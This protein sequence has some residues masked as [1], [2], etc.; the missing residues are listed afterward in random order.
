LTVLRGENVVGGILGDTL[1]GNSDKNILIGGGGQDTL[2]GG[3]GRDLLIGGSG[4]DILRGGNGEDL[5]VGGKTTYFEESTRILNRTALEAIRAEWTRN[6][7]DYTTRVSHLLSGGGLNDPYLL[8]ANTLSDDAGAID[9]LFG[10]GDAD[11]FLVN[12]G[13]TNDGGPGETVTTLP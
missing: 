4:A 11:W 6:E 2:T 10:E 12:L 5:L 1:T 3:S 8:A 7:A 13:D 9:Q